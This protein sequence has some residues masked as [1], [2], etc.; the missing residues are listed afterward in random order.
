MSQNAWI[1]GLLQTA[2]YTSYLLDAVVALDQDAIGAA[3]RGRIERQKVLYQRD[4]H[5][6]VGLTEAVLRHRMGGAVIMAEQLRRL[7]DL[8]RLPTVELGVIPADTD[9]PS[10]Y[11]ASFDLFEHLDGRD[12]DSI[13]IVE[14]EAGEVREGDPERVRAYRVRRRSRARARGSDLRL[15]HAAWCFALRE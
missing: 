13:V 10:R 11:G 4:T 8:S 14:L 2:A 12:D 3:V 7:A 5:L 1:P 15:A 9:M 6:H